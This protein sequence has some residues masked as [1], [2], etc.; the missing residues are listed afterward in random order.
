MSL[1][2]H[3]VSYL[4]AEWGQT[5]LQDPGPTSRASITPAPKVETSSAHSTADPKTGP[6]ALHISATA[7]DAAASGPSGDRGSTART[8][9]GGSVG[10]G[11][12]GSGQ[13]RE[14]VVMWRSVV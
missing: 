12:A 14:P 2:S 9:A 1:S 11:G 8:T 5:P 6:G 3:V 13:I 4:S 10:P 7:R